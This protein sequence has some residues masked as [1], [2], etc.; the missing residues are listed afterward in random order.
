[1]RARRPASGSSALYASNGADVAAHKSQPPFPAFLITGFVLF[2]ALVGARL[3][4]SGHVPVGLAVAIG[5]TFLLVIFLNFARALAA[6]VALLF[7]AGLPILSVGPSA[8]GILVVL[9]WL[10]AGGMQRGRLPVLRNHR[11]LLIAMVFFGLW[12]TVSIAWAEDAGRA[13]SEATSW[14][15]P[16]LVFVI[17]ASAIG[18]PRDVV[19]IALAF[20]IGAA[21]AVSIG[22]LG[23][24]GATSV[25]SAAE[26][27]RL[28]AAGDPNYQAAGFLAAM[29][30]AGG[31][32]SVFRRTDARIGVA[33]ALIFITI[34]FFATESRGGLLALIFA[35]VAAF[36]LFR[37]QR[38]QILGLAIIGSTAVLVWLHSRPDALHRLTTF[39][40]G[41]SGREDVWT[42]AWRIFQQ[43][44]VN[45]VGMGNFRVIEPRYALQPGNITHVT[46]ISETPKVVHNAYL[47][48]MVET[49]V[50]GFVAFA[51]VAVI[52]MRASWVAAARFDAIGATGLGNLARAVLVATIGMLAAM[53]FISNAQ[54]YR[55][56][57]L[58]ALGPV[59]NALSRPGASPS[60]AAGPV[61]YLWGR[62]GPL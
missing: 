56:W 27:G 59:L 45:G 62:R 61:S 10:G 22:L 19:Y 4:A 57:I 36:V 39:G 3:V 52:S 47:Q 32:M 24:G 51:V 11:L 6:W 38:P 42:V 5:A 15:S 60:L 48:L 20:V 44:P 50:I 34:G 55:L 7:I 30:M 49:G 35:L 16:F 9:A 28:Q 26:E 41:G 37:R 14:W 29:F 53:F 58:F 54:D 18:K 23:I 31:L 33:I 40:G 43:H 1:M 46:Y 12:L 8:V 17:V 13:A 25:I 21:A 2:L